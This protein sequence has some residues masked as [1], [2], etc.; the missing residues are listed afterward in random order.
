MKFPRL[1]EVTMKHAIV[2]FYSFSLK[3]NIDL[4]EISIECIFVCFET[5]SLTLNWLFR[6]DK[7]SPITWN[8]LRMGSL[9]F[10]SSKVLG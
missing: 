9:P 4:I 3:L 8:L 10:L 5:E 2:T 1:L 7:S 6:I